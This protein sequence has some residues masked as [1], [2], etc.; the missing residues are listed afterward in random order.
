MLSITLLA[1]G[2]WIPPKKGSDLSLNEQAY[3]QGGKKKFI[4]KTMTYRR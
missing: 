1:L 3:E 2:Q 4:T